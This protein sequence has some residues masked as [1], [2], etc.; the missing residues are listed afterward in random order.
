MTAQ[1]ALIE[2]DRQVALDLLKPSDRDLQHGLELHA[3]ALV[4]ESYG[5][6]PRCAPDGDAVAEAVEAGA[7]EA[8]LQDITEDMRMTRCAVDAHERAEFEAAWEASGVT[9]ILQNAGEEGQDPLRLMKRLA[10]FTYVTDMMRD[11]I[12]KAVTPDDIL[13]AKANGKRCLYMTGN[14]VPLTQDWVS[15]EDELRYIRIFFQLGDFT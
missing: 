5:F 2:R 14:G 10:R 3:D 13:T 4:I 8:E 15:V 9:C 1:A 7:S 12:S 11:F 6:S